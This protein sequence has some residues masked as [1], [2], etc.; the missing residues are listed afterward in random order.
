M[1]AFLALGCR[2]YGRVDLI[3]DEAAGPQ[4]LEVNTIPGFTNHSL[5]PKAAA[6]LGIGFD[7]LCEGCFTGFNV[8]EDPKILRFETDTH[9]TDIRL[10]S[11]ARGVRWKH[12]MTQHA[13]KIDIESAKRFE[14]GH[15]DACLGE[16]HPGERSLCSHH[17]S[18]N[19]PIQQWPSVP[20]APEGTVDAI[21]VDS[22]MAKRMSFAARW[23]SAWGKPFDS[24]AFLREHPQ[25]EWMQRPRTSSRAMWRNY[26]GAGRGRSTPWR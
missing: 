18:E 10:S 15:F 17:E 2:D 11:V 21:V 24:Q 14:A 6:H 26:R 16:N 23:G 3:V 9:E 1:R 12:L 19:N 7:E 8:A 20:N 25:F 13:G 22:T 5:L 4:L